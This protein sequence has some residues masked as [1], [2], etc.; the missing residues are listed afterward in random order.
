M[1]INS[2]GNDLETALLSVVKEK[3]QV[4]ITDPDGNL[5]RILSPVKAPGGYD[6]MQAYVDTVIAA[7]SNFTIAG[8]FFGTNPSEDYNFAGTVSSDKIK[9]TMSGKEDITILTSNLSNDIDTCNGVYYLGSD[10]TTEHHVKEN[11]LYAAVYRDV[12]AAFNFGYINGNYGS[13]SSD[14]WTNDPFA[15]ANTYYN[16]YASQITANYPGAYGFPFSDRKRNVLM[17]LGGEVDKLQL[18]ILDDTTAITPVAL[19]GVVNPQTTGT[20]GATFDVSLT[21]ANN[22]Q[23]ELMTVAG[24]TYKIGYVNSYLNGVENT[25]N[26]QAM[27]VIGVTAQ[28]GWNKY[29]MV[30]EKK[31]YTLIARVE[32]GAVVQATIAGGGNSNF[33][34]GTLF[35]GGLDD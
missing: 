5:L 18:T 28:D 19:P 32:N 16:K 14:W 13:D 22:H 31:N 6:S 17:D 33:A 12:M 23:D 3:T 24:N 8:T 7:A 26:G 9:L 15:S 30:F 21:F 4:N 27:S 29:D 20:N 34:T 35:A 11:D 2:T 25:S 10:M 1:K